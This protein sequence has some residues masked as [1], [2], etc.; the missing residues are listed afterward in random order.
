MGTKVFQSQT[1]EKCRHAFLDNILVFLL[2]IYVSF[3]YHSRLTTAESLR[4]K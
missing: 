1:Q 2:L 4:K 3:Q